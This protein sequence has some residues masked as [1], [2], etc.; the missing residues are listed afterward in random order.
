M[1]TKKDKKIGILLKLLGVIIAC[2]ALLTIISVVITKGRVDSALKDSKGTT[3]TSLCEAKINNLEDMI[4]YQKATGKTLAEND[5]VISALV[6]ERNGT[7]TPEMQKAVEKLINDVANANPVYENIFIASAATEFGYADIH[8]GATLH[9]ATE[10][11]Y[12]DLAGGTDLI[13]KASIATTSGKAVY[14]VAYAIKDNAGKFLG[15][16]CM[17]ID[18][19]KMTESII[20][21]ANYSVSIASTQGV[22]LASPDP[23]QVGFDITTV[24]PGFVDDI[25]AQPLGYF[26]HINELGQDLFSGYM[27]NGNFYIEV[28]EDAALTNE[29]VNKVASGMGNTLIVMSIVIAAILGIFTYFLIKPFRSISKEITE[30][31]ENLNNGHL[32]LNHRLSIKSKDEA[33]EI[34]DAFNILMDGLKEAIQSVNDCSVEISEGNTAI[35]ANI[36]DSTDRASDI[37]ALTEE[38]AAS[39][40]EVTSSTS[41]IANDLNVL[42]DTV[43]EV[44]DSTKQNT[45][46]VEDIKSR[47]GKVKERTISNKN[48]ILKTIGER[49]KELDVAIEDSKKIED[50]P[51]LTDEI[52]SIASQT[53]LLALNA[54]IE[55]ARAGEAGRGFA[56]VAEE[57]RNLAD[58]SQETAG[59]IQAIVDDVV[60]SVKNLM[61]SS[62]EIVKFITEKINA[63]YEDFTGVTSNYYEDAEKMAQIISDFAMQMGNVA[64]KTDTINEA[65][66]T[67]NNNISECAEGISDTANSAQDLNASI[68]GIYEKSAGTT[69]SL[70]SLKD[71][72]SKFTE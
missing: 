55:A 53:N 56:V 19:A 31:A 42:K 48:Q 32:N 9:P 39:M 41:A 15:E 35:A 57:I 45:S 70:N 25:K 66:E 7:G 38:L 65:V 52:L 8:D 23:T 60:L 11:T 27:S 51:K 62:G 28:A 72:L 5:A 3:L 64:E 24:N 20:S 30:V 43:T 33:K 14:I 21:D 47:A 59:N 40:Q 50:I 58:G 16:L 12:L 61:T 4:T 54:S 67:I 46:F 69:E 18:V 22:I 1:E 63:D 6:A 17:G 71:S 2:F 37:G 68:T 10:Q 26:T 44:N 49:A 36:Q 34:A 29:M 13:A